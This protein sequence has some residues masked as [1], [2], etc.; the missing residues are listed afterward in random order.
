MLPYCFQGLARCGLDGRVVGCG[1]GVVTMTPAQIANLKT[2]KRVNDNLYIVLEVLHSQGA[3]TT[4]TRTYI[5]NMV[6]EIWECADCVLDE[7]ES[8]N[9]E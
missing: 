1:A 3:I 4:E 9:D 8:E 2:I 5:D 6:S 7:R